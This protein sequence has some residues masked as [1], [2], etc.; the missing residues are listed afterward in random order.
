MYLILMIIYIIKNKIIDNSRKYDTISTVK[1]K[2]II[3]KIVIDKEKNIDIY[4][5]FEPMI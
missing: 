1:V 5:K 2:S 4:Y 3:D